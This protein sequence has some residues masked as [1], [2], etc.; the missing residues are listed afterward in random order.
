MSRVILIGFSISFLSRPHEI[1]AYIMT[2]EVMG[3]RS[4]LPAS[5]RPSPWLH[6]PTVDYCFSIRYFKKYWSF[7][8]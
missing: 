6:V 7:F 3:S 8:N 1:Q 2:A 5:L 4:K